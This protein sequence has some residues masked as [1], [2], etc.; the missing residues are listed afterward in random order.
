MAPCIWPRRKELHQ[1]HRGLSLTVLLNLLSCVLPRGL[2]P[3][4]Q[5]ERTKDSPSSK[6][7][8]E[9]LSTHF[10]PG[11]L[12][13]WGKSTVL[14]EG[15]WQ[16]GSNRLPGS[17]CRPQKGRKGNPRGWEASGRFTPPLSVSGDGS[18]TV[19]CQAAMNYKALIQE[20][21]AT[22]V[23]RWGRQNPGTEG[24][25]TGLGRNPEPQ[26]RSEY[27]FSAWT[28]PTR[29]Q[30]LGPGNKIRWLL[31]LSWVGELLV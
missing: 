12:Y 10:C 8:M 14:P 6:R 31:M 30:Q 1:K 21:S 19:W 22:A 2:F 3:S 24:R 17:R 25:G 15:A 7:L 27:K 26:P 23:L 9:V 29:G 4:L 28:D 11:C 18:C 5:K 16:E 20:L 13:H